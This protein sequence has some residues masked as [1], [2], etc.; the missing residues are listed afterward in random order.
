MTD[1]S[2]VR[3]FKNQFSGRIKWPIINQKWTISSSTIGSL[4]VSFIVIIFSLRILL[5]LIP[6]NYK[7]PVSSTENISGLTPAAQTFYQYHDFIFN[8]NLILDAIAHWR[9]SL[10]M[11]VGVILPLIVFVFNWNSKIVIRFMNPYFLL[12]GAH[13]GSLFVANVILGNGAMTFVS[14]FYSFI[15][16]LQLFTLYNQLESGFS[17]TKHSFKRF[18]SKLSV[19]ILTLVWSLNWLYLLT[20]IILVTMGLWQMGLIWKWA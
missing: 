18:L 2:P 11:L 8:S 5:Y 1:P 16:M 3:I 20:F 15:R 19:I 13:A 12:I 6:G 4:F 14:F 10:L 7:L 17:T 9:P